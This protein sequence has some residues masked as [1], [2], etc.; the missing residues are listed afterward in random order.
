MLSLRLAAFFLTT[1]PAALLSFALLRRKS[2]PRAASTAALLLSLLVFGLFA[3]FSHE[4]QYELLDPSCYRQMAKSFATGSELC[5]IHDSLGRIPESLRSS[6]FLRPNHFTTDAFFRFSS[7][8]LALAASASSPEAFRTIPCFLPMLPLAASALGPFYDAFPPLMGALWFLAL[9]SVALAWHPSSPSPLSTPSTP[10]PRT[11][12]AYAVFLFLATFFPAWF[13]RGF[14]ADAIGGTLISIALLALLAPAF[15]GQFA[16]AGFSLAFSVSFHFT[17]A[18]YVLPVALYAIVREGSWRKTCSL[19]L[20]ALAGC[21]LV[22]LELVVAGSPYSS[23]GLSGFLHAARHI[24]VIGALLVLCVGLLIAASGILVAAHQPRIRAWFQ[25][26]PT[27]FHGIPL[28]LVATAAVLLVSFAPVPQLTLGRAC[29][30]P[31][32]VAAF[33]L[34]VLL[35]LWPLLQNRTHGRSERFLLLLIAITAL[36]SVYL[37][38]AEKLI[39][40]EGIWGYR[41]IFPVVILL[42]PL[43]LHGLLL[44]R[45]SRLRLLLLA[46]TFLAPLAASPR[47]WIG[48]HE[49]GADATAHATLSAL[50]SPDFVLY[51]NRERMAL[52]AADPSRAAF[53]LDPTDLHGHWDSCSEWLLSEARRGSNVVLMTSFA[54]CTLEDGVRLVPTEAQPAA[55]DLPILYTKRLYPVVTKRKQA[56]DVFLAVQPLPDPLPPAFGQ[57]K[58]FDGS[59]FGLRGP[60]RLANRGGAWSSES[61]CGIIGPVPRPDKPIAIRAEVGWFPPPDGPAATT[62]RLLPPLASAK[63]LEIAVTEPRQTV[64]VEVPFSGDPQSTLPL[65]GLWTLEGRAVVYQMDFVYSRK[66]THEARSE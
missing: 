8:D 51:D 60:W 58:R 56:Q 54:P 32:M 39:K 15:P 5:P 23:G 3:A 34:L 11:R 42:L 36:F 24:P 35:S 41:R 65:T 22:V 61:G 19:A 6:F 45:P 4:Y 27:H 64:Q 29:L 31:A 55:I 7:P 17:M 50:G 20:A 2:I 30:H 33:F 59:P 52:L 47:L 18:L 16:L 66:T 44:R 40:V 37:K 43:C 28:V 62:L 63:P 14:Y 48:V 26:R 53:S 21:A 12:I 1:L 57:H 46:V 9:L 10:S 38:G 49:K 13:F 25:A